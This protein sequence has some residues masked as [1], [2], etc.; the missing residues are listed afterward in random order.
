MSKLS[1]MSI[2]LLTVA[3]LG[4]D[5]GPPLKPYLCL[6]GGYGVPERDGFEMRKG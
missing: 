1:D 6:A 2:T 3:G 5:Y 4:P